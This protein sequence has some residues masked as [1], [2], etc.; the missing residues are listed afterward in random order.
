MAT[1][2]KKPSKKDAPALAVGAAVTV[3]QGGDR[4][5]TGTIVEDFGE[6]TPVATEYDGERIAD[7]ARRWAVHTA[8]GELLFVDS[9][10]LTVDT[11]AR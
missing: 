2:S 9:A 8:G 1:S 10:D 11:S 5:T 4:E 3:F 6:F 7:P